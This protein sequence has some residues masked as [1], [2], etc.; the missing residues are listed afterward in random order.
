MFPPFMAGEGLY[1]H[2]GFI[3]SGLE[4]TLQSYFALDV[5]NIHHY[6]FCGSHVFI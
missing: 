2:L 5:D 4:L 6:P 3:V 1:L